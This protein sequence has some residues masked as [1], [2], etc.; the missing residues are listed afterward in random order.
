VTVCAKTPKL[1]EA[2]SNKMAQSFQQDELF[3]P[4]LLAR[5]I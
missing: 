3:D 5:C 4:N 1:P 2:T